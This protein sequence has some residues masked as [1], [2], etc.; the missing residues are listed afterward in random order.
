MPNPRAISGELAGDP[1]LAAF[2]RQL[3]HTVTMPAVP[4]MRAVWT[5]YKNALGSVISGAARP[6][7]A[8]DRAAGEIRA[9]EVP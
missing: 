2:R 1:V 6:G 7:D 5:P 8:L 3:G 4:L 9:Y